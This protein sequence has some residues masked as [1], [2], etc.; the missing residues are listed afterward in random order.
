[1][2]GQYPLLKNDLE[3]RLGREILEIDIDSVNYPD[4]YANL[5]VVFSGKEL[6]ATDISKIRPFIEQSQGTES[7]LNSAS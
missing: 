1:M 4:H 5:K 7:K 2:T 6:V 3:Y